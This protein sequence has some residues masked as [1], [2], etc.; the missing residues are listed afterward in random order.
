MKTSTDRLTAS[1]RPHLTRSCL[2]LA[3]VLCALGAGPPE[4]VEV[5]VPSARIKAWFPPDTPWKGMPTD[6]FENLVRAASAGVR[7]RERPP[8]PRLLRAHHS[9]RWEAGVL[10][11]RSEFVTEPSGSSPARVELEPWTP[12]IIPPEQGVSP[13]RTDQHGT[14]ALW[15][16]PSGTTTVVLDWQLRSSPGSDGRS[17]RL[18]L[19]AIQPASL[20]LDLPAGWVPDGPEASRRGPVVASAPGRQSWDFDGFG[21]RCELRLLDAGDRSAR[22]SGGRL[23]LSGPTR[24]ALRGPL[25][26]WETDWTVEALPRGPRTL[27]VELDPGLDLVDV[28]GPGVEGFRTETGAGASSPRI[29]IH[30]VRGHPSPIRLTIRAVANVPLEGTWS[31]PSARPL[32]AVWTGGTTTVGLDANHVV[33]DCRERAGRRTSPRAGA[34]GEFPSLAF[35][36]SVPGSVAD[37][38]FRRPRATLSAEVRG[39]LLLGNSAPRLK[40]R[41][42]WQ[43]VSGRLLDLVVDLPPAWSPD[44]IEID[45]QAQPSTWHSEVQPGGGT[46]VHVVPPPG[47]W[48]EEPLVMNLT[49]TAAIAGGRGPLTLPRV[50]PVGAQVSDELWVARTDS[51]LTL[52]PTHARGLAW[53]DPALALANPEEPPPKPDAT[54]E[55]LAWRWIAEDAEARVDRDRLAADPIGTIQ[56]TATVSSDQ[57]LLD[58]SVSIQAGTAPMGSIVLDAG[59]Q[60]ENVPQWHFTDEETGLE[61]TTRPIDAS[62]RTALG[63]P[64]KGRGWELSLPDPGRGHWTLKATSRIPWTGRGKIPILSLPPTFQARG[65]VL[66]MADGATR[67]SVESEGLWRLDPKVTGRGARREIL[68]KSDDRPSRG[69]K[70]KREAHAFGYNGPGGRLILSTESLRPAAAGV[71]IRDAV[72]TTF[73][74]PGAPSRQHLALSVTAEGGRSLE[75]TLPEGSKLHRVLRDGREVNPTQVGPLLS[76]ALPAATATRSTCTITLDYESTGVG[77][78]DRQRVTP[79]LPTVSAACLEFLWQVVVPEPFR[80]LDAGPRLVATDPEPEPSWPDRIWG[81]W[82]PLRHGFRTVPSP[83]DAAMLGTLDERVER[84]QRR[85]LTLDDWFT[86]L[87]A[88][89]WPVVIDR[90]ALASAGFGPHSKVTPAREGSAGEGEV[91]ASLRPLG[92]T[93]IPIGDFLLITT[94][95]EAPKL[96]RS[97]RGRSGGVAAWSLALRKGAIWGSDG[98]DRFQSVGHWRGDPTP[99]GAR[100][101]RASLDESAPEGGRIWRFAAAGWPGPTASARLVDDRST[102]AWSWVVGLAVFFA[103]LVA[104]H[105]P[106][107]IRGALVA[108]VMAVAL[109]ALAMESAETKLAEGAAVGA[110]AVLF[111]WLGQSLR[112]IGRPPVNERRTH[113][114]ARV[115]LPVPPAAVG[116]LLLLVAFVPIAVAEVDRLSTIL[117]L[118]PFEGAADPHARGDRVVLRLSDYDRLKA[119]AEVEAPAMLVGLSATAATHRLSWI[120]ERDLVV[121]SELELVGA[122]GAST[123]WRF[124]VGDTREL[125][126]RLN[127]TEVP[128]FVEQGGK[129]ASVA[130]TRGAAHRLRIRRVA[131]PQENGRGKTLNLPINPVA[132]TRVTVPDEGGP[133]PVEVLSA[134]GGVATSPAGVDGMLGPADRLELRWSSKVAAGQ[135]TTR[136]TTDG[137][138]LWDAEPAGD[139]VRVKITYR[140]PEGTPSV[141]IAV[142]PGV[143]L[144]DAAIPGLVDLRREGKAERPEWVANVDPPLPDGTTIVLDFWR[145]V[146]SP[147]LRDPKTIPAS[148]AGARTLRRIPRIE[149]LGVDR[150]AGSLGFRRPADWSGRLGAGFGVAPISDEA[151]VK[152]WGKLPDEPLTLS[153]TS[154]F[155][156]APELELAT[157]PLPGYLTVRPAVQMVIGPGRIDVV[158]EADLVDLDVSTRAVHF[159]VPP[160]LQL[161]RVE[162]DGMTDWSRPAS[163][164]VRLRFD[165]PESLRRQV[166]IRGWVPVPSDPL[167]TSA[168]RGEAPLPWPRWLGVESQSGTLEI[169]SPTEFQLAPAPGLTIVFSEQSGGESS[170][171]VRFRTKY[172]VDRPEGLGRLTWEY[173][174]PRAGVMVQSH[175]TI[176]PDSAEW[177]AAVTYHVSGGAYDAIHLQLPTAWATRAQVNLEG[178]GHQLTSVSRR[179]VTTWVIRPDLPFWGKR[180][181]VVRSSLPFESGESLAFP[182]LIPLGQGSAETTLAIA[183]ATGGVLK[184]ESSTGLQSI[185][186]SAPF[187][188][189]DILGLGDFPTR[190]FAVRK[191]GWNLKVTLPSERTTADEANVRRIDAADVTLT[192]SDDGSVFG[193]ARF[194]VEPRSKPFLPVDLPPRCEALWASVDGNPYTPLRGRPGHWF[195]PLEDTSASRVEFGWRAAAVVDPMIGSRPL[196]VPA[197]PLAGPTTFVTVFVPPSAEVK[198]SPGSFERVAADRRWIEGAEALARRTVEKLPELARNSPRD[199]ERVTATLDEFKGMLRRAE[200]AASLEPATSPSARD[201]RVRLVRERIQVARSALQEALRSAG[202]ERIVAEEETVRGLAGDGPDSRAAKSSRTAPSLRIALL[203][204]PIVFFRRSG[205]RRQGPSIFWTPVPPSSVTGRPRGWLIVFVAVATPP[206]V[207]GVILRATRRG[208]WGLLSLSVPLVALVVAGGPWMLCL[209]AICAAL[210]WSS[211]AR[212]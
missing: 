141:R 190:I 102:A 93:V 126:A 94:A 68:S 208:R 119:S 195:I 140:N 7:R 58:W 45:G 96:E 86:R 166:R 70:E 201:E 36:A 209:G 13:V 168:L 122:G 177:V 143:I 147:S 145:P 29:A 109:A 196:P 142:E 75:L 12:A 100:T 78:A 194:E 24:I 135:I 95:A 154:R 16:E 175:L 79:R 120:D 49:A 185:A 173:P 88:G 134:R 167:A 25:A 104:R 17:F 39:Q 189:R 155:S 198:G 67:T 53:I 121:V 116:L 158:L 71:V 85:E 107:P 15:V 152:L 174:P 118:F 3:S 20:T 8:G 115:R 61:V 51:S 92:L 203:G 4:V 19:P 132:T 23:W 187:R 128:V 125:S 27:R 44:R 108:G 41:L 186:D 172:R 170:S 101:G 99:V 113:S 138:V 40:S 169:S 124:P 163:D 157:G 188:S 200:R 14:T 144:R 205:E 59:G 66:V 33:E 21:G 90:M 9:A 11:G 57:L 153:G 202:F 137:L 10:R 26:H 56:L 183:N 210:G 164:Q 73:F 32:N 1:R 34:S 6:E 83:R 54:R 82:D 212:G 52:K 98:S 161:V 89:P 63:F 150:Y 46:R 160:Q 76:I 151:F 114:S 64:G 159:S 74:N 156:R 62:R 97:P 199:L 43:V 192:L 65:V 123:S 182:D 139:R 133:T 127:D 42:T 165:G 91:L 149:P 171:D 81:A 72:L 105:R 38:V 180:R 136:G 193:M 130:V 30:L 47:D 146:P 181:L 22:E 87:D 176:H 117:A 69:P 55:A 31:V 184:P 60:A 106:A 103:G 80:V 207:Y 48:A 35:E 112:R 18:A 191:G 2:L 162:A 206:L 178:E 110:G 131:T 179:D 148:A 37:L 5:R 28:S 84:G 77:T 211:T 197:D 204:R 50:R 129:F 111:A